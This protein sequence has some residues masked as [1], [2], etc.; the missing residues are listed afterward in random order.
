MDQGFADDDEDFLDMISFNEIEFYQLPVIVTGDGIDN[1][2]DVKDV[3][4]ADGT[5]I[6]PRGSSARKFRIEMEMFRAEHKR[7]FMALLPL[8]GAR[9]S[10]TRAQPVIIT[11]PTLAWV[12]IAAAWV[13][14]MSI[15]KGDGKGSFSVSLECIEHLVPKAAGKKTAK[16]TKKSGSRVIDETRGLTSD[17]TG[18]KIDL[19]NVPASMFNDDQ[20]LRRPSTTDDD[21]KPLPVKPS[22]WQKLTGP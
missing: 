18:R 2:L 4:G 8:V 13:D 19:D 22:W 7:A 6:T 5:N 1:K 16:A 10:K 9:Y 15:P 20:P 14:K 12:N 11:Y 3:K 21:G 17:T